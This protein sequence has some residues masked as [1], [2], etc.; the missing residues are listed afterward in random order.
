MR[1][2]L[3][4]LSHGP[5]PCLG[6]FLLLMGAAAS[7]AR[8]QQATDISRLDS[9][10]Q[11]LA[12]GYRW[13]ELDSVGQLALHRGTDYPVLRRRLGDAALATDRPADAIGHY[14]QALRQHPLDSAARYGL[15]VAYLEMNQP[16]PAALVARQLPA[17]TRQALHL[18]SFQPLTQ[19]EFEAS[20][21][22][23]STARRGNAGFL[24]LGVST[25]LSARL[26]LTQNLSYFGQ[27]VELP[28]PRRPRSGE[29]YPIRQEQYHA[30]LGVQLSPRWRALA[31]YHYL[32][33]DFDE[34]AGAPGHLGYAALAY[35][36]PYWTA[37]LGVFA[38]T[39]TDTTRLQTDLRLTVYPLG[40]LR[41]YTF[42]RASVV[43]SAGRS[44]P[45][46]VLGAGG[47]LHRR[48]WLEAF[49]GLGQVPVL[50]ELDGTYVYNL[51]DPL[52]QRGGA[53]LLVLLP[54]RLSLRMSYGAEQRQDA[55]TNG[56]YTLQSLTTALAWTW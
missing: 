25:R 47:R 5:W 49:G 37:Q 13:A 15:S 53:S 6:L 44:Y 55:V 56:T 14:G 36:R 29:R 16:A 52:R 4:S 35:A 38:G 32:N 19:V 27:T 12:V 18:N 22:R 28:D 40:N 24:R 7:P 41:L 45:N 17:A 46:G 50:A 51:L 54:P 48:L 11:V 1:Q 34:L 43:R 10:T 42:G 3:T 8:A 2:V 30:L 9:L 31:G 21:Q 39:L 26:S 20:G 23:S 33:S